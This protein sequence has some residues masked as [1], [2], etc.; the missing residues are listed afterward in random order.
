[1]SMIPE[2]YRL[3]LALAAMALVVCLAV[4]LAG[5]VVWYFGAGELKRD[6]KGRRRSEQ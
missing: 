1:M 2:Q 4:A 6:H 5:A 3:Y